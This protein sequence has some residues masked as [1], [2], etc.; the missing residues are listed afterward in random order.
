MPG[1]EHVLTKE[2]D[3]IR[4]LCHSTILPQ[5]HLTLKDIAF[6]Q[7][8]DSQLSRDKVRLAKFEFYSTLIVMQVRSKSKVSIQTGRGIS[9]ADQR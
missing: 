8:R 2:V 6:T 7:H 9:E 3:L 5:E 4:R 1:S